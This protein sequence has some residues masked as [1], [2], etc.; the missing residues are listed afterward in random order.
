MEYYDVHTYS[1]LTKGEDTTEDMVA[2]AKRL[3]V[4]GLGIAGLSIAEKEKFADSGLDIISTYIIEA[5][6]ASEMAKEVLKKRNSHEI[7][8]VLG[9]SYEINRAACENSMVDVLA[10]P[11]KE[12]K[13]SGIDHILARAAAENDVA[14]EINFR[15]IL[16]NYRRQRVMIMEGIKNNIMLARKYNTPMITTSAAMTKW[17]M[18]SGR[19]L[20]SMSNVL[21]LDL[22]EAINSVTN[23]PLDILNKNREK[24]EGTRWEGIVVE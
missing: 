13:D 12:R 20:S 11:G 4:K 3:G 15:E 18:R 2:M 6:T 21:G 24:L 1:S 19:D 9:G 22:P 8:I 7:L 16:E 5:K 10:H 17:N 14:I 23:V